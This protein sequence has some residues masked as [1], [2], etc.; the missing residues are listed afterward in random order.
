MQSRGF[1]YFKRAKNSEPL[2]DQQVFYCVKNT[3]KIYIFFAYLEIL[4]CFRERTG[5]K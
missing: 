3:K 2:A 4:Y 5:L 1:R